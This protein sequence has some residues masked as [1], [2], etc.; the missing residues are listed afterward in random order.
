MRVGSNYDDMGK[1]V[2]TRQG[3]RSV[4]DERESER[5]MVKGKEWSCKDRTCSISQAVAESQT[6]YLLELP[7]AKG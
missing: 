2:P 6:K 5:E 1:P 3:G 4:V 7:G